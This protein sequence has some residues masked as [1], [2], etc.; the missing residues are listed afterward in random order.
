M[1]D[2]VRLSV[3]ASGQ[4]SESPIGL[5]VHLDNNDVVLCAD[6]SKRRV[7]EIAVWKVEDSDAR[8][9]V[10]VTGSAWSETLIVPR[11]LH[12]RSVFLPKVCV[13]K[14]V[15]IRVESEGRDIGQAA[16]ISGSL[17]FSARY[18][19][20]VNPVRSLPYEIDGEF[21]EFVDHPGSLS[22][23]WIVNEISRGDYSTGN[24]DFHPADVILD[25]GGHV[26]V[27]AA[28]MARRFP[29][30]KI[31]SFE[32][33]PV[34]Y[35]NYAINME[36]NSI[37]SCTLIRR[38]VGAQSV[39]MNIH[40]NLNGGGNTGGA[41]LHPTDPDAY[42]YTKFTVKTI[43]VQE[44]IDLIGGGLVKLLKIDCEGG[45]Y[46]ILSEQLLAKVRY[47][48]GEFHDNAALAAQGKSAGELKSMCEDKLGRD[49]VNVVIASVM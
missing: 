33:L 46:D 18:R 15:Y 30:L 2:H 23:P 9:T 20:H 37:T 8:V 35:R 14:E 49:Y 36:L 4:S 17:L 34:N 38:P 39:D 45:E 22:V 6:S 1:N 42:F 40:V 12:I 24:I 25:I 43:S 44:V 3:V 47:I 5:V 28:Y 31:F 29:F 32:P 27:F 48:T 21:F 19:H 7:L 41:S 11:G 10:G 26:G 16:K 13:G